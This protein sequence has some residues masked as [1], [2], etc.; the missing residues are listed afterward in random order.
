MLLSA[1]SEAHP[2][3]AKLS[4]ASMHVT[5]IS[6]VHVLRDMRG[7]RECFFTPHDQALPGTFVLQV[8]AT[9]DRRTPAP[10]DGAREPVLAMNIP[11]YARNIWRLA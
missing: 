6:T 3:V 5:G 2:F 7:V 8:R 1:W 11:L 10:Q 9:R 4:A